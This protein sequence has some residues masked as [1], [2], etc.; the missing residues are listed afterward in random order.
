MTIEKLTLL[1]GGVSTLKTEMLR[2]AREGVNSPS[3]RRL[4]EVALEKGK[5]EDQIV[6]ISNFLRNTFLYQPDPLD[7]ELLI[8][9]N[10]MAEDFLTKGIAHRGDCDDLATLVAAVFGSLGYRT[11]ILIVS[12]DSEWSHAYSEIWTEEL[13]WLPVDIA[14]SH[15]LGWIIPPTKTMVMVV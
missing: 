14:S 7:K 15:P 13:G 10:R 12:Y 6:D 2:L 5:G 4:G 1:S 3:V 8:S 11:R 9:P